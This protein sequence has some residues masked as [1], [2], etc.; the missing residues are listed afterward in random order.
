MRKELIKMEKFLNL[1][2]DY[3]IEYEKITDTE[4]VFETV[5]IAASEKQGDMLPDID[6]TENPLIDHAC[7]I[8]FNFTKNNVNM[9][10]I[11]VVCPDEE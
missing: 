5:L 8:H 6:Y 1:L 9:S 4:I 7:K 10:V 2:D 3:G 11:T